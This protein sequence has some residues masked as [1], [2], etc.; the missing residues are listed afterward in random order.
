[1]YPSAQTLKQSVNFAINPNFVDNHL[2]IQRCYIVE[3][4]SYDKLTQQFN[5]TFYKYGDVVKNRIFWKNIDPNNV[6]YQKNF[7]EDFEGM[8]AQD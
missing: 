1:I 7:K 8:L 2:Q 4:S 6:D 5:L 3:L